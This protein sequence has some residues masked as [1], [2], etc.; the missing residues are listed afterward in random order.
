MTELITNTWNEHDVC[1]NPESIDCLAGFSLPA[2]AQR[3]CVLALGVAA[4]GTWR[5]GW[6]LESKDKGDTHP[7]SLRNEAHPDRLTAVK[8]ALRHAVVFFQKDP[9]AVKAL[10]QFHASLG[11]GDQP[12]SAAQ[13]DSAKAVIAPMPKGRFGELPVA[14]IA[15]DPENARKHFDA[16]AMHELADSIAQHG[17]LQPIAVRKL[18]PEEL[19]EIPIV[20]AASP[21]DRYEVILGNR[22]LRAHFM[23]GRELVEVK[24]Y[25]GVSRKAAKAAALVENLQR[26]D[27]NPIEEAEG[28]RDLMAAEGL[29]QEQLAGRVNRSRPSVANALRVLSLPAAVVDLV[30]SGDLSM[31][32]GVALARFADWPKHVAIIAEEAARDGAKSAQLEKGVPYSRSLVR[33]GLAVEIWTWETKLPASIKKHPAYFW[34][35]TEGYVCF[36]PEHWA[37]E[38]ARA[39]QEKKDKEEAERK[40]LEAAAAKNSKKK[41]IKLSQLE[42]GTYAELSDNRLSAVKGL[43]RLIPEEKRQLATDH[44]GKETEICL[45]KKFVDKLVQAAKREM[46]KDRAEKMPQIVEEARK[47]ISK[48]KKLGERENAWLIASVLHSDYA[49]ACRFDPFNEEAAGRQGV[50]I[51]AELQARDYCDLRGL[52]QLAGANLVDL[53]RVMLD[54]KLEAAQA[55]VLE[56]DSCNDSG[57]FLR[58][59]LERDQLGFLEETDAGKKE[60]VERVKNAP[61]YQRDTDEIKQGKLGIKED[62]A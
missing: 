60:I 36:D 27:L 29:T 21:A 19:G 13:G 25:E 30:R 11:T 41:K 58:W 46:K 53:V 23:L 54:T 51:P 28:Y 48:I 24:I 61:W 4:D 50:T 20:A 43:K 42:W 1:Q 38:C 55:H 10:E 22:R 37:A 8:A 52:G 40:E 17:L 3:K 32:H 59:I 14:V 6:Q 15:E 62:A 45:D 18:L 2:R 57:D 33:A 9:K 35:T 16:V 12:V 5:A 56:H 49:N 34:A 7:V 39:A 47:A 44:G 31:A 26:V